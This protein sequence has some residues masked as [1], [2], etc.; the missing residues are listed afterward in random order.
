MTMKTRPARLPIV[1]LAVAAALVSAPAQ[2]AGARGV[3][4]PIGV[5]VTDATRSAKA[6]GGSG[7]TTVD[8]TATPQRQRPGVI[9][10]FVVQVRVARPRGALSYQLQFGDGTSSSQGP[11]P[12]ICRRTPGRAATQSWTLV[13][14][15]DH[16]G[17]YR[18]VVSG[19]AVCTSGRATASL[20]VTIT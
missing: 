8:V 4:R 17:A 2:H 9:V 15:Y 12:L 6:I 14:R 11:V 5:E 13:H 10:R 18:V 7:G 16:P 1:G 20:E 3:G 19:W